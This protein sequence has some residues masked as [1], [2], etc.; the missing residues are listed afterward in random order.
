MYG[1]EESMKAVST[2]VLMDVLQVKKSR[3]GRGSFLKVTPSKKHPSESPDKKKA[4]PIA[5]DVA[6][7]PRNQTNATDDGDTKETQNTHEQSVSKTNHNKRYVAGFL[8]ASLRPSTIMGH[9]CRT[10]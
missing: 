10:V 2:V 8:S 9:G 4:V 7:A 3:P 6:I 5:V 1:R